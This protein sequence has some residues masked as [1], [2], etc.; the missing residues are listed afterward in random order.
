[1]KA[2]FNHKDLDK[3]VQAA[4][5][6]AGGKTTIPVLSG[7]L[8]SIESEKATFS[9]SNYEISLEYS[10]PAIVEIPGTILISGR[11]FS[12][13]IKKMPTDNITISSDEEDNLLV[14]QSG[15]STYKILTMKADEFPAIERVQQDNAIELTGADLQ[16]IHRLTSFCVATSGSPIFT[17]IH[18]LINDGILTA[19]GSDTHC[20][21]KK[22]IAFNSTVTG[23]VIIPP[24]SLLE[25]C[26]LA[27]PEDKVIMSLHKGKISFQTDSIYFSCQ[28]IQGHR[29]DFERV[30]PKVTPTKVTLSREVF[31]IAL[32]R[33]SIIGTERTKDGVSNNVVISSDKDRMIITSQSGEKGKAYEEFPAT[34]DGSDVRFLF[35]SY[36]ITGFLRAIDADQ[37]IFSFPETKAPCLLIPTDDDSYL[38]VTSPMRENAEGAKG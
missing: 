6:I 10:I 14:V 11:L 4:A 7:I 23:D 19:Y 27:E 22:K 2:I 1:M 35:N 20:L 30:I 25:I 15:T 32:E 16:E 31:L 17:G 33:V 37:I 5:R 3:A 34:I 13:L 8:V 21:A 26:R 38:Y 18:I 28:A 36:L 24:I 12:D 29:P 9:A